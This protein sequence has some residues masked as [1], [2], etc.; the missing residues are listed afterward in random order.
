MIEYEE[1]LERVFQCSEKECDYSKRTDRHER[2]KIKVTSLKTSIKRPFE[3]VWKDWRCLQSRSCKSGT[4]YVT[5]TDIH[6]VT[7]LCWEQ[8]TDITRGDTSRENWQRTTDR[9]NWTKTQIQHTHNQSS[10][11]CDQQGLLRVTEQQTGRKGI[12]QRTMSN[13]LTHMHTHEVNKKEKSKKDRCNSSCGG[14]L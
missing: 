6:R 1:A 10:T 12:R 7:L 8:W 3:N 13:N 2:V 5:H 14:V 11:G 4:M 9:S